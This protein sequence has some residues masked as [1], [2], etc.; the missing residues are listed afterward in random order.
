MA[1]A[2][3]DINELPTEPSTALVHKPPLELDGT[4]VTH[5][6]YGT[7]PPAE[8]APRRAVAKRASRSGTRATPAEPEYIDDPRQHRLYLWGAYARMWGR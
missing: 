8:D 2:E 4:I 6:G 5:D 1:K 7:A 3:R